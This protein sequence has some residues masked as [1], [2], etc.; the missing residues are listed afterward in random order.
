MFIMKSTDVLCRARYIHIY[1]DRVRSFHNTV[2]NN[3]R[4]QFCCQN[5]KAILLLRKDYD[6]LSALNFEPLPY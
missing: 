6:I 4:L 5:G 2:H 3:I 1:V